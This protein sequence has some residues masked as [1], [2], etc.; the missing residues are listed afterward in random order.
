MEKLATQSLKFQIDIKILQP[1][2]FQ[3]LVLLTDIRNHNLQLAVLIDGIVH[4]EQTI[5]LTVAKCKSVQFSLPLNY[6][7]DQE[8]W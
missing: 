2:F 3:S 7:C 6:I 8:A 1:T 5:C 4:C